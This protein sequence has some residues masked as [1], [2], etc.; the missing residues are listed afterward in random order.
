MQL[1]W[2]K[3]LTHCISLWGDGMGLNIGAAELDNLMLGIQEVDRVMLGT[4]EV[5]SNNP[6]RK[7]LY[8]YADSESDITN[9]IETET[10]TVILSSTAPGRAYRAQSDFIGTKDR[11]HA[12][13]GPSANT[14]VYN[15]D[16]ETLVFSEASYNKPSAVV[17]GGTRDHV[18]FMFSTQR[19]VQL[20]PATFTQTGENTPTQERVL[21]GGGTNDAFFVSRYPSE[22]L[23]KIDADSIVLLNSVVPKDSGYTAYDLAGTAQQLFVLQVGGPEIVELDTDTLLPIRLLTIPERSATIGDGGK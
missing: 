2:I 13:F 14:E 17:S 5:W 4:T 1:W 21:E 22:Y 16:R 20:D 9:V 11:M 12:F 10:S 23:A 19:C 6:Y 8:A 18:F 7:Y 15:V 3:I